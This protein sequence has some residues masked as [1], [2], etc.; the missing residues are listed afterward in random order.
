MNHDQSTAGAPTTDCHADPAKDVLAAAY[1]GSECS[2]P[3]P[4]I[5]ALETTHHPITLAGA[6]SGTIAGILYTASNIA[7]RESV[8]LDPFL[9]AAVKAIPTV[10]CLVPFLLVC[11]WTGKPLL[12]S[13]RMIPRF[14]VVALIGQF[15]GNAA[16]QVSLG[17]I[18]LSIT[19]PITMGTII[20]GAAILGRWIL[21]EAV[22]G[23][24]VISMG[25]LLIAILVLSLPGASQKPLESVSE[26]PLWWGVVCA[27]ASGFAYALFGTVLRQ[28]LKGGVS[29]SLT[30]FI[31]GM[32]G[33]VSLWAFTWT[34]MGID[35]LSMV[36]PS[37]WWVMIA[38]GVLNFV[39]FVALSISLKLLPVVAVNLINA[40]QVAMAACAG[41]LL[42]AEPITSM[43]LIGI[44]LTFAGLCAL[45]KR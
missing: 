13:S 9:V 7:L 1:A 23:S 16:F 34:R 19:V 15:V 5:E 31:S 10:V 3:I 36:T 22:G 18:G 8:D 26:T 11:L 20:I 35:G 27:G 41:V 14:I 4:V 12:T 38:A 33:M 24:T 43:M 30:M 6:V 40:S 45:I 37:Q 21:K 42:F 28:T 44:G 32:V 29:A 39:A 25:I 17:V 2:E